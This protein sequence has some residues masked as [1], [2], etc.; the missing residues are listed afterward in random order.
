LKYKLLYIIFLINFFFCTAQK[1]EI[2]QVNYL[3][4]IHQLQNQKES[5]ENLV[6]LAEIYHQTGNYI[7][8]IKKYKKALSIK[9]DSDIK[10]KLAKIFISNNQKEK[11]INIYSK[12]I[13]SQPEN[14]LIKYSLANLFYSKKEYEKSLSLYSELIKNDTA[15]VNY[16]YR[17]ASNYKN[18][19]I[20]K[21]AI[22]LYKNVVLK[23][24][25]NYKSYYH[26][27]KIYRKLNKSDSV[28]FYLDKGLFIK[29]Y[30]ISLNKLKA[31]NSFQNKNYDKVIESV[32]RLD[33]IKEITPFYQNLLGIAYYQLKDYEQA[34]T[35]LSK[36]INKKQFQD[37]TFYYLGL[38]HQALKDY[39]IA[40]QYFF[41]SIYIKK[42]L[43]NKEYYQL[44]ML[45]KS[46]NKLKNA[47][48]FLKKASK[49]K[50]NDANTLYELATLCEIY[51]KDKNEALK[52]YK[53]YIS[54]FESLNPK[55]TEYALQQISKIKTELFMKKTD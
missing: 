5:I 6:K 33:S 24:S 31:K 43:L 39:A 16:I 28:N 4:K 52:Y 26:L 17:L 9:E 19:K 25:N 29:P 32:K 40:E 7:Q 35:V 55:Q 13:Q 37:E 15:N 46:Q 3:Q 53:E 10:L 1:K 42:P 34:K 49:E 44:A 22:P 45:Y 30:D 51:Y 14:L 12:I 20:Y 8:A 2:K 41:M 18:L 27:A 47:I 38:T 50:K 21:K 36:L 48:D 54:H 11:A 23:D